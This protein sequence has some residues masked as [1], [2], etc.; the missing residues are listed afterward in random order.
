MSHVSEFYLDIIQ[1][2]F[3]ERTWYCMCMYF[4]FLFLILLFIQLYTKR[5]SLE[6][7][8][9]NTVLNT[10]NRAIFMKILHLKDRI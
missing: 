1:N 3:T 5:V 6:E 4:I 8:T 2:G 7:I 10:I 9:T